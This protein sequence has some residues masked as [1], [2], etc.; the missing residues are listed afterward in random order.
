VSGNVV[1]FPE[2]S[3]RMKDHATPSQEA[4][5]NHVYPWPWVQGRARRLNRNCWNDKP[6]K[7]GACDHARGRRY[8]KMM[9]SA[10]QRNSDAHGNSKTGNV[11]SARALDEILESMICDAVA[12]QKKGGHGSRTGITSTMKGFLWEMTRYIAGP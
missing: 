12:R 5:L 6:T 10:M 3:E 9:L 4:P 7:N 2:V 11:V 8:A 1:Q